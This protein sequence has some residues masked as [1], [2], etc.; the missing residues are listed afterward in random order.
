MDTASKKK[1][2]WKKHTDF[3]SSISRLQFVHVCM[4]DYLRKAHLHQS[5][6]LSKPVSVISLNH[7]T[8]KEN[9]FHAAD[10]NGMKQF[11]CIGCNTTIGEHTQWLYN[12]HMN[13][14][15]SPV[16]GDCFNV[17]FGSSIST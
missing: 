10:R 13:Q 16:C 6:V 2:Q 1:P 9:F 17:A 8:S 7:S 5:T 11:S 12:S 14:R 3:T 15:D 4:I